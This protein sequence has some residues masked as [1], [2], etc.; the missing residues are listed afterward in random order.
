MRARH[1]VSGVF[2]LKLAEFAVHR[3]GGPISFG[4]N[5]LTNAYHHKLVHHHTIAIFSVFSV[6]V[7]AWT[8]QGSLLRHHG[9]RRISGAT[10][11]ATGAIT[12]TPPPTPSDQIHRAYVNGDIH[13]AQVLLLR[14]QG[15]EITSD[16]DPRIAVVKDEDF[17]ACFIPLDPLG[18]DMHSVNLLPESS[19]QVPDAADCRVDLKERRRETK[20]RR[21]SNQSNTQHAA[22]IE[23]EHQRLIKQDKAAVAPSDLC[24][25][26]YMKSTA[27][28]LNFPFMPSQKITYTGPAPTP[29][30]S[31]ELRDQLL[32]DF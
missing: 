14:L 11:T 13:L 31:P 10:T 1:A 19:K 4:N 8:R 26:R 9:L 7:S 24:R 12:P 21:F 5:P 22:S 16:S 20:T 18:C 32:K 17:D 25:R 23:R 2:Q 3:P 30:K 6:N 15:I 29:P 28:V 27:R